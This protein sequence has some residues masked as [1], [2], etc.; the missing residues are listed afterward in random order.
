MVSR[1][2]AV[3]VLM[4]VIVSAIFASANSF[5]LQVSGIGVYHAP[6]VFPTPLPIARPIGE[7]VTF[8]VGTLAE[9]DSPDLVT[10]IELPDSF[11]VATM[12]GVRPQPDDFQLCLGIEVCSDGIRARR[13]VY[14]DE[15]NDG[16]SETIELIFDRGQVKRLLERS[17]RSGAVYTDTTD[18]MDSSL[19]FKISGAVSGWPTDVNWSA[20]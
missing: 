20:Q 15:N 3:L 11:A 19:N 16:R 9:E 6:V 17:V 1:I 8:K 12:D 7:V 2:L 13:L 10:K 5:D 18:V 14:R 4:V